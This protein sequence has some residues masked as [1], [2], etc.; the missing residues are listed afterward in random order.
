[1]TRALLSVALARAVGQVL[2]VELAQSIV[3]EACAEEDRSIPVDAFGAKT[4]RGYTLRAEKV[5]G[6]ETELA[7][8]H[9]AYH[10]E[11]RPAPID[12]DFDYARL[13]EAERAGTVAM[14]TARVAETG[15]LVGVMRVRVGFTLETQHMTA[16]D[17]MFFVK[18]EH[19]GWLAVQLWKF[20]EEAMFGYG[21]REVTF[22]SLTINGAE[23]MARFLGYQQ[24]AI[25]FH[26]VAQE[27]CNYSQ[28]PTRHREGVPHE[29][30]APHRV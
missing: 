25:K 7:P 4:W 28:V 23:R 22:D 11:T 9:L 18:P 5:A 6:N 12:L 30:L 14:F 1:M 29:P 17:D 20:A 16:C 3:R 15:E 19:R 26:K 13:R 21:V 2:T 10:H 27:A 24:V 8:L